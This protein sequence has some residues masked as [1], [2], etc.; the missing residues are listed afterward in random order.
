MVKKRVEEGGEDV[1]L[2]KKDEKED[3]RMEENV[4]TEKGGE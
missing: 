4:K 3:K 2:W 1:K